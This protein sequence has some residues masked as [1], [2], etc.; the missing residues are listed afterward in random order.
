MSRK[1][2]NAKDPVKSPEV[3]P[4]EFDEAAAA[5]M[6]ADVAAAAG[7]QGGEL[8][9]PRAELERAKDQVLRCRA[10]LENYR[11][12]VAR[13]RQEEHRYAHLPLM[14][15]LLPVL[16]NM[17]RAIEAGEQKHDAESLLEGV[18][19]VARQLQDVLSKHHCVEIEAL[20][21]AFDPHL[22]EAIL[23]QPSD[24]HPPGTVLQVTQTGFRLH[25]RVARPAQVIVSTE[26]QARQLQMPQEGETSGQPEESDA[27]DEPSEEQ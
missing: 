27:Q 10:E 14:R 21:G 17:D 2:A 5:Q 13:E 23:Q 3:K 24:E 25:D 19:M 16:D 1:K 9:S 12:R 8:D 26:D 22:H 4:P 6:A 15:D 18:K 11:K 20:G 7:D